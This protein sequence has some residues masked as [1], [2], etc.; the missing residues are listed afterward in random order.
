MLRTEVYDDVTRVVMSTRL[1]RALGYAASAYLVRGALVDVGFPAVAGEVA[2]YL[3]ATRPGGV[4][5][6]HHH[7]D[8][9]GNV[10][11]VAHRGLPIGAS[12]ATLALL[13]ALPP[14]GAYRRMI[15]GT[16]PPLRTPIERYENDAL[17]LLPAPGHSADHHV[18]WDA[19]RETL[20]AGDLFLSVKVRAAHPGEKPRQLTRTLRDIAALRPARMFDAHR[21]LV[22]DPVPT[23]LAKADWLDDLITRIDRRIADG[24]SDRAIARA[25]L[26]RED[27]AHYV[28]LGRMSRINLVRALRATRAA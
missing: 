13:R 3:D 25:L 14:L 20:I 12:D 24:S 28:S 17:R 22:R 8:H 6:T 18:V 1:T 5:L 27:L 16:P 10:E 21:G 11:L 23:L 2:A 7:E 9:A 15:W 19:E 4:L 26:G